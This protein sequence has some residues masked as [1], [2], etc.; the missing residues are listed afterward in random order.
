MANQ[1]RLFV[2]DPNQEPVIKNIK[3]SNI[4]K[5]SYDIYKDLYLERYPLKSQMHAGV[6]ISKNIIVEEFEDEFPNN[7][8]SYHDGYI[9]YLLTAWNADC[10]IEVGPW[11]IWNVIF[12][13]FVKDVEKNPEKYRNIFT[14][15]N[16]K[17]KIVLDAFTFDINYLISELKKLI[18]CDIDAFIPVFDGAPNNFT[19]SMYGLF[20]DMVKDYYTCIVA[21]CSIPKVRVLGSFDDWNKLLN[22]CDAVYK[23]TNS[24]YINKSK[25]YVE[26][27]ITNLD[28]AEYWKTFFY[29]KGCGSGSDKEILGHITHFLNTKMTLIDNIPKMISRFPFVDRTKG[30]DEDRYFIS[31]IMYSHLDDDNILVPEYHHNISKCNLDKCRMTSEDN[32]NN[33]VIL[34]FMR[35]MRKYTLKYRSNHYMIEKVGSVT[36]MIIEKFM[37]KYDVCLEYEEFKKN[38]SKRWFGPIPEYQYKKLYKKEIKTYNKNKNIINIMK[39]QHKTLL[40]ALNIDRIEKLKSRHYFWYAHNRDHENMKYGNNNLTID[41]SIFYN[42]LLLQ[43]AD[44]EYIILHFDVIYNYIITGNYN[45]LCDII[46]MLNVDIIMMFVTRLI[47]EHKLITLADTPL[48]HYARENPTDHNITCSIL[49]EIFSVFRRYIINCKFLS[50]D[51]KTSLFKTFYDKLS[52][53]DKILLEKSYVLKNELDNEPIEIEIENIFYFKKN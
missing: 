24:E 46:H 28:N 19:E 10:G 39:E 17:T 43:K 44:T 14:N 49:F 38:I 22:T 11:H 37:E 13:T 34:D 25:I 35:K 5:S 30:Y 51:L 52:D 40:E 27:M 32:D 9:E 21:G 50:D 16:E 36:Q 7:K 41:N 29:V 53:N 26:Q 47:T 8:T 12:S 42:M 4:L 6:K 31:G 15:N 1:T 23:I 45:I 3:K 2:Y 18:P 48:Y 20:A 33:N